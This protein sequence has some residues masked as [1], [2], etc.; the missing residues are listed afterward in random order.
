MRSAGPG[1]AEPFWNL[2]AASRRPDGSWHLAYGNGGAIGPLLAGTEHVAPFACYRCPYGYPER[3][4]QPDL[5]LCKMTC[6][7]MLRYVLEK[8][9]DV[10]AVIAEPARAV[11]YIPP[12][13]FWA[14]VRQACDDVGALLIFD[15]IPTG[16]GKTGRM[17]ACDHDGVVPDILVM[18]KGLG[19]GMPVAAIHVGPKAEGCF[20][21]REQNGVVHATTLGGNCLSMAVAAAVLDTIEQDNLIAHAQ[22]LGDH[23]IARLRKFAETHPCITAVRGKVLFIGVELDLEK[24]G[25]PFKD[26]GELAQHAL[27]KHHLI[28]NACQGNVLRIAPAMVITQD[29]FDEG[30]TLLENILTGA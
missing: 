23:A 9:G 5:D 2:T 28:I 14:A 21:Y 26:A 29:E 19:G 6:A 7:N 18:G 16:L 25:L 22:R 17:F 4:G 10:A 11:P 12:P 27:L 13:G 3:D 8:E 20:D 1:G 30:L 15:E 24:A